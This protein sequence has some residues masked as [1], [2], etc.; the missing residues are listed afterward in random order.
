[1]T[2]IQPLQSAP[3]ETTAFDDL[4]GSFRGELLPPTSPWLRHC[5]QDLE[6]RDRPPSGL[7]RPLHWRGRGRGRAL[8]R[9]RDLEIAVR[10][11]GHNVAGTAGAT[12][13]S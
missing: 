2:A 6:R 11:G 13:E 7:H 3:L 9:G 5:L 8:A 4:G 12:T 10:G 1:M